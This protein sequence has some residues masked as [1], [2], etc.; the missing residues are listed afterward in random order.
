MFQDIIHFNIKFFIIVYNNY[1][2]I[3]YTFFIKKIVYTFFIKKIEIYII[4]II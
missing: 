2:K 1:K 4:I 3:V